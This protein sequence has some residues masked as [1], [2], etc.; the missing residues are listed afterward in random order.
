M[1]CVMKVFVTATTHGKCGS[2]LLCLLHL[3]HKASNH[4]MFVRWIG[5]KLH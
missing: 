4:W 3:E 1:V 2:H 5:V